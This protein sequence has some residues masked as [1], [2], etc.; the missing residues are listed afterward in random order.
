MPL[1]EFPQ[2]VWQFLDGVQHS[3]RRQAEALEHIAAELSDV[4]TVLDEIRLTLKE[5]GSE[6]DTSSG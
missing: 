1:F 5:S 2:A 6:G 3:Q 4:V